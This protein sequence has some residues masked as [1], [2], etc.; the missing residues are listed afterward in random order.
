MKRTFTLFIIFIA[1]SIKAQISPVLVNENIANY[2][3]FPQAIA[4][5]NG[6]IYMPDLD[7]DRIIK[8][9][10][11]ITNAP[12]VTVLSN[13]KFPTG[14]KIVGNEL[15]FLQG[16]TTI[17]P[18]NNTGKLSKINLSIVNPTVIDV[19]SGLNI[20]IV[21]EGNSTE[22][23]ITEMIGN[24]TSNDFDDFNFQSTTVS[25][26]NL[27]GTPVKTV[28]FENR[29]Y[30]DDMKLNGSDIY[31]SEYFE[32]TDENIIFK[33]ITTNA[34]PTVTQFHNLVNDYAI[35]MAISNNKLY[36]PTDTGN[37]YIKAIDLTQSPITISTI[38]TQF[39]YNSVNTNPSAMVINGNEMIVSSS[40]FNNNV[41]KELLYK[42]DLSTLSTSEFLNNQ[43]SITY[44]PNPASDL[45][46]FEIELLGIKIY[47][48]TGRLVFES[49]K[50]SK[51]YDISNLNPG[52]YIV[53][54]KTFE[55]KN[56]K[57]KLIKK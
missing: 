9:S 16:I 30:I 10:A 7:N 49:E 28:L 31:W 19:V 56:L 5:Y 14:I 44:Y 1:F 26:I 23:F 53:N 29:E 40:Y 24:F 33:Y 12:I 42:L 57:F 54:G 15:Y 32:S 41:E 52:N 8:T 20:P 38:S 51:N 34:T 39:F 43:I 25:K 36:F 18:T 4:F 13:V 47:D 46:N 50:A 27:T 6:E 2:E 21:L 55:N 45:I 17:N 11:S 22:M 37:D 35:R 3:I 48:L